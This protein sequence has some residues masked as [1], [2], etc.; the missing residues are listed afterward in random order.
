VRGDLPASHEAIWRSGNYVGDDRRAMARVTVQHPQMRLQTYAM[1]STFR[2]VPA[3]TSDMNSFN[4][5]PSGIDPAHGQPV[6]NT[7]ADYLWTSPKPPLEL[8]NVKN[9]SWTRTTDIDSAGCTI[10]FWNTS[11]LPLGQAPENKDLDRPGFYTAG[12]GQA[13]FSSR[14]KHEANQWSNMLMPDNILRVYEGYGFDAGLPPEED[15]HLALSGV[16]MIDEVKLSAAGVLVCTCRDMGRLLIDHMNFLPVVPDDFYPTTF[17]NWDQ[18]VTVQSQRRISSTQR[19]NVTPDSS[20]NEHWPEWAYSGAKVYGHTLQNAFDNNPGTYWLSV[21]NDTPAYRSSYEYLDFN[22]NGATVSEVRFT[23]VGAGYNVYLS[24]MVGGSWLPGPVVNYHEDGRGHY[25][26]EVTPYI[27]SEGGLAGEGEHVLRFAPIAGVTRIRLWLNNLQDFGL[28]SRFHYRAGVREIGAWGPVD[29]VV[30]DSNEVALTPGPTGSNPGRCQ[31]FTDIVKLFCGW[32]G[33]FWPSDAYQYHVGSTVKFPLRP[34]V[35]DSGVLG[36]PVQGRIWGDFQI[37]GASPPAEIIASVF[38]KKTLADGINY[39]AEVVGFMFFIDSTGAVQWRMPNVWSLGNWI[40]GVAP[41]PGRT[42]KILVLDERQVITGL[43]ASIQSRN[44]REGVFVANAVGKY[45]A[46]VGG[47]NPN[48]TGLRRMCGW[49]DENF[50]TIDEARVMADLIAVKQL[51]KYRQDRVV[52]PG[53]LGIEI[54]DQVRIFER[55]TSEGFIHYV[56]GV[57]SANDLVSG[58][59]TM[60]LQTHWLGDDP[61]GAWVID[62]QMLHANTIAYVDSLVAGSEWSRAGL[63]G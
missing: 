38:D 44:V 36:A 11:P 51:F 49:T 7:Y 14:W 12:R 13:T 6:T 4:P 23:T 32:A 1:Q 43:D 40:G 58:K 59:W 20:G 47:F 50:K 10:E 54:D 52:I 34:L 61:N 46:I 42:N 5:Y 19:I 18:K 31:D 33:L 60:T 55:V 63:G 30:V 29:S 22:A 25:H 41:R 57:S 28:G 2:K 9:V 16:W 15:P 45:A 8:P 35:P 27:L 39:I 53:F 24:V 48:D 3:A 56:Q 21:G 17:Q 62:K 37:T 26:A